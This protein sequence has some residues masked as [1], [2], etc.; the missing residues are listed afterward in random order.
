M[1]D[2]FV[3]HIPQEL[4]DKRIPLE[5]IGI[6]RFVW[7]TSDALT[8]IG[9]CRGEEFVIFGGDVLT[10]SSTDTDGGVIRYTVDNWYYEPKESIAKSEQVITS[11]DYARAKVVYFSKVHGNETTL[12]DLVIE[13][14]VLDET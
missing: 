13:D 8:I 10:I 2:R 12:F 11:C 7:H 4:F 5:G 9:I 6:P 1:I 3:N 14:K